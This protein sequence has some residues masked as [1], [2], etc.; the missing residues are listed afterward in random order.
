MFLQHFGAADHTLTSVEVKS[1]S[2]WQW[3][4]ISFYLYGLHEA[5]IFFL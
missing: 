2:S 4:I 5:T 3:R 1:E